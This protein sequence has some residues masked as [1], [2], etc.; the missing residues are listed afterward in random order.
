MFPGA[1][2]AEPGKDLTTT[3]QGLVLDPKGWQ[4]P[5]PPGV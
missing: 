1:G 4:L 5:E 3:P 2:P